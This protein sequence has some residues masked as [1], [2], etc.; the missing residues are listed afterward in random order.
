M[1][2][3]TLTQIGLL[4]QKAEH[5]FFLWLFPFYKLQN[6]LPLLGLYIHL[7]V[8]NT[9][10]QLSMDWTKRDICKLKVW[11]FAWAQSCRGFCLGLAGSNAKTMWKNS[12]VEQSCSLHGT[13]NER[14]KRGAAEGVHLSGCDLS[15]L[16]LLIRCYFEHVR[17]SGD[18]LELS[19]NISQLGRKRHSAHEERTEDVTLCIWVSWGRLQGFHPHQLVN[20]EGVGPIRILSLKNQKSPSVPASGI[21]FQ[22][23]LD[24]LDHAFKL[25]LAVA[26]PCCLSLHVLSR[27]PKA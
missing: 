15:D 11:S 20:W 21:W 4:L 17:L 25:P 6:S 18:I 19:N 9:V 27:G 8:T 5:D 3:C 24:E 14:Q 2:E 16:L 10:A 12:M 22:E 7:E 26:L 1:N 13:R 23:K